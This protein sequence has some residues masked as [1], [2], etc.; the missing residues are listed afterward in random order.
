[1]NNVNKNYWNKDENTIKNI[2]KK[3]KLKDK[4]N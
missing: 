3:I 2:V 1:M 4:K